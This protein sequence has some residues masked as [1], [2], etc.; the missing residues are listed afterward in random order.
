[1]S[2]M[3][4]LRIP[5]EDEIIVQGDT[6][7]ETS[8]NFDEEGIDLRF[9]TIKMQLFFN[10]CKVLDISNDLGITI[11]DAKNCTIDKVL[12]EN[13]NLPVGTSIGDFEITDSNGDRLTY[14]RVEYTITQQYTK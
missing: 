9:S 3:A 12:K 10:N 14:F 6:I 4:I 2:S 11:L 5:F 1:M 7:L 13:N 8:L